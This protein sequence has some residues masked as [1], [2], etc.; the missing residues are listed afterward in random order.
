MGKKL[1]QQ[2][3]L[4]KISYSTSCLKKRPKTGEHAVSWAELGV[5]PDGCFLLFLTGLRSCLLTLI[6]L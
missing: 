6:Y 2:V 5:S 4:G 1:E 3:I